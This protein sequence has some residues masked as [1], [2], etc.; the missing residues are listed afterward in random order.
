MTMVNQKT[1]SNS[2]KNH[3]KLAKNEENC[4][5]TIKPRGR[6]EKMPVDDNRVNQKTSSNS[7][8][9]TKTLKNHPKWQKMKNSRRKD[10]GR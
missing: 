2:M 3:Q 5:K 8:K 7:M 10:A 1:T 6:I 4:L 9:T